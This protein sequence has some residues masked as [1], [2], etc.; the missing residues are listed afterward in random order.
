MVEFI[1][2]TAFPDTDHPL[3]NRRLCIPVLDDFVDNFALT[4]G[5][6]P[7]ARLYF[8]GNA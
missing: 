7:I 5:H 4:I 1:Q 2:K 6:N 8:G 3:L